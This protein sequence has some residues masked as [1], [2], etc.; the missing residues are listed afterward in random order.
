MTAAELEKWLAR[1]EPKS[2]GD[3]KGGG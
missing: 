2:V 1:D 3:K